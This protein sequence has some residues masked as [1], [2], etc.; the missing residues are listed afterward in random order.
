RLGRAHDALAVERQARERG[1][2]AAACDEDATTRDGL[3]AFAVAHHH[4][5]GVDEASGAL[6]PIDLVLLEEHAEPGGPELHDLV[7]ARHHRGQ[8]ELDAARLDAVD[9]ETGRGLVIELARVEQRLA[10]NAADV[11][12][13]AAER[14]V[15]LDDRDPHAE[16][17]GTD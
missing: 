4:A 12:A 13:R 10:R 1:R 14:R 9:A 2:L 16:L 15:L 17:R 5:A 3:L 7:L 8:V 6:H 11:E